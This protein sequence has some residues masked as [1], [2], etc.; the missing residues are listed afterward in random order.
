[1]ERYIRVIGTKIS[2]MAKEKRRGQ[3]NQ[4]MMEILS[5]EQNMDLESSH[6]QIIQAMS[7]NS[8]I[9]T[10]AE[11]VSISGETS[12]AITDHGKKIRC[13]AVES[14]HG[15]TAAFILVTTLKTRKKVKAFSLGQ[16]D[17][18][19]KDLGRTGN[20]MV[21]DSSRIGRVKSRSVNGSKG[22]VYGG[23]MQMVIGWRLMKSC[24]KGLRM[25]RNNTD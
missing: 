13:T 17:A 14:S 11:K 12:A 24:L 25:M 7:V 8:S 6:G 2:N 1:M 5:T 22:N 15:L 9:I 20:K 4:N 19:M 23:M 21:E 18:D 16:M 3:I 10:S